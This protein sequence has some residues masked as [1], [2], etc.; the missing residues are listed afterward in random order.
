MIIWGTPVSF[1]QVIGYGLALSGLIYYKLGTEQ[2]K[3]YLGHSGR[4]WSEFGAQR[5]ALRK[6]I[7][8]LAVLCIVFV[9]LGGLGPT[10]APGATKSLQGVLSG[11]KAGA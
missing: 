1:L 11:V 7:T 9:F 4:V 5:P 10:Y 2:M 6:A 3:A 8:I